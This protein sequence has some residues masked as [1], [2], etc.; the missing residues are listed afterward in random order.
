MAENM[1]QWERRALQQLIERGS[2]TVG[3]ILESA[4]IDQSALPLAEAW[5]ESALKRGL[6]ETGWNES[7]RYNIT[8][9]G[10]TAAR[11]RTRRFDVNETAGNGE[12]S[13]RS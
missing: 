5:V 10:R 1:G 12:P 9:A 13:R 7:G 2:M 3:E 6:I 11:V 8:A 4:R